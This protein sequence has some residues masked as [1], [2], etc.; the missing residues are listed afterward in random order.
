MNIDT[1]ALHFFFHQFFSRSQDDQEKSKKTHCHRY[2]GE[3]NRKRLIS[4]VHCCTREYNTKHL[5]LYISILFTFYGKRLFIHLFNSISSTPSTNA[6][7]RLPTPASNVTHHSQSTWWTW[8][9]F[10]KCQQRY[11]KSRTLG[12]DR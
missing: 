7:A 10:R 3:V 2:S 9:A 12:I 6:T 11:W 8:H 1:R 5:N 4:F